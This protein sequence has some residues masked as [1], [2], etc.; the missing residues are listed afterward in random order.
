MAEQLGK[1]GSTGRCRAWNWPTPNGS[2]TAAC[3]ANPHGTFGDRLGCN[4]PTVELRTVTGALICPTTRTTNPD[5]S[6][7]ARRRSC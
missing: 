2:S 7:R 5:R 1:S 6:R 3:T 4:G